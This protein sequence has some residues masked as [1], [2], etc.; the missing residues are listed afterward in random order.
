MVTNREA[1]ERMCVAYHL[2]DQDILIADKNQIQF[3]FSTDEMIPFLGVYGRMFSSHPNPG[4]DLFL[5]DKDHIRFTF[6]IDESIP[7]LGVYG[8]IFSAYGLFD[9]DTLL[10]DTGIIFKLLSTPTS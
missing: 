9:R 3:T 1:C 5:A 2:S 8:R 7:F 4:R 6:C 10:A